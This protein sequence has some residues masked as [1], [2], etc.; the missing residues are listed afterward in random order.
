MKT[1]YFYEAFEEEAACLRS[2]LPA[3]MT[4]EFSEKTIQELDSREPPAEIVSVRTQSIIPPEWAGKVK[5]ILA[6]TTGYDHMQ[7]YRRLTD[8]DVPCGHLPLYCARA[9]AEQAMLLW[10]ALIRKLPLQQAQFEG[11]NRDGLTGRE[12]QG[13]NLLVVGVGNIGHEV[14]SIA[15]ALGMNVSGV[16]IVP[17]H[18]DV[19][20]V[21]FEGALA[22]ADILVCAMNLTADNRRYFNYEMLRSCKPGLIFVNV[23]RGECSP[24]VDLVRLI[25]AGCL[26]AVGLDVYDNEPALAV[27]ARSRDAGHRDADRGE[28]QDDPE[29][30]AVKRLAG[31]S[32]VILT[33][34]NAFNTEEAVER[35]SEQSVT[36]ITTFLATGSF[37]WPVPVE[38]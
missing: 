36:Q 20:Y 34:H 29:K 4:A 1:V 25:E 2:Y 11:F 17:K 32:N 16:D 27:S 37:K 9:V 5:A 35:K 38:R 28:Q 13:K 33:P 12:C 10:T 8:S 31:M 23:S 18:A 15:T 7:A 26:G 24:A 14:V 3:E 6:R 30:Q 19:Q 22:H 21:D